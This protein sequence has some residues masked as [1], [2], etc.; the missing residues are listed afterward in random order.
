ME[1]LR[2]AH[3]WDFAFRALRVARAHLEP[4]PLLEYRLHGAN[5][6]HQDRTAMVFEILWV[7][8]RHLPDYLDH[9]ALDLSGGEGTLHRLEQLRHS[10]QV[11]GCWRTFACLTSLLDAAAAR[12][13]PLAA[14]LLQPSNPTRRWLLSEVDDELAARGAP[15][16]APGRLSALRR[17][18]R[19]LAWND[20][21]SRS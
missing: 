5:T 21:P 1:N 11:Y 19:E 12:G 10:L 18:L 20:R 9:P 7:L 3:D 13:A 8:A 16:P 2:F 15:L 14:Q 4:S 17:H 6:I